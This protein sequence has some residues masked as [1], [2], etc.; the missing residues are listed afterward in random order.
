MLS[1]QELS[2]LKTRCMRAKL[3]GAAIARAEAIIDSLEDE[4]GGSAAGRNLPGSAAHILSLVVKVI[5]ARSG[6][7]AKPKKKAPAKKKPAAKKKK[8]SKKKAK[9]D[10]APEDKDAPEDDTPSDN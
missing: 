1:D 10:G 9:K 7:T 8:A 5:A 4:A 6:A 3:S 2:V